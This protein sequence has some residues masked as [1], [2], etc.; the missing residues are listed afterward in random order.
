MKAAFDAFL[1]QLRRA[2]IV[3]LLV[4]VPVLV[5]TLVCA[6]LG[7]SHAVASLRS[8]TVSLG[9]VFLPLLGMHLAFSLAGMLTRWLKRRKEAEGI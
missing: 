8:F 5:A 6:V 4:I 1:G 9:H 7:L 2:I 3:L